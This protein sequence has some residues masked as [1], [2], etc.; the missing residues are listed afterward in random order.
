ML[1][2]LAA[3]LEDHD[4]TAYL[5]CVAYLK[6][7]EDSQSVLPIWYIKIAAENHHVQWD[8]H[9]IYGHFP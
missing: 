1:H 2:H 7:F 8:I 9:Y 3:I 5:F 4:E 6:M